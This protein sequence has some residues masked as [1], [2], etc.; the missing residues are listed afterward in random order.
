[1][2]FIFESLVNDTALI[3]PS[4]TKGQDTCGKFSARTNG[5]WFLCTLGFLLWLCS[6]VAG[7]VFLGV[8]GIFAPGSDQIVPIHH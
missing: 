2:T 8:F 5:P 6:P 3:I 4:S 7:L 1:M